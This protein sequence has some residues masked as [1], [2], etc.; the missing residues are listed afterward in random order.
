MGNIE[1]LDYHKKID[2]VFDAELDSDLA[3]ILALIEKWT[4]QKPDSEPILKLRDTFIQVYSKIHTLRMERE[5]AGK[6]MSQYREDKLRA[7]ERARKAEKQLE[8]KK[9]GRQTDNRFL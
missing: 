2:V 3:L 1:K 9:D 5:L 7:V 4:E 6:A 8:N